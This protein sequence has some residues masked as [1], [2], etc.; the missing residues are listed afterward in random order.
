MSV[1][2]AQRGAIS[3]KPDTPFKLAT[4]EAAGRTR[5]GL[6]IGAR[7]IDIPGANAALVRDERLDAVPMPT[8]MRALIE[9]YSR[10]SPRL[11]QIANHFRDAKTDAAPYVFE[12]DKVAIK[13]PIKYPYNILA[14]AANYKLHAGEM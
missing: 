3:A 14:A 5:I 11:Y 10:V 7:V 2:A 4:F 12:L 8:E 6:V 13:A 9:E 1:P